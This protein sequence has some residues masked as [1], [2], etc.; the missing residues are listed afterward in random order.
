M[1]LITPTA[2]C[3]TA[4]TDTE[5]NEAIERDMEMRLRGYAH[6][7][8][9]I[10]SVRLRELD[11]EWNIERCLETGASGMMLFGLTMAAS[12]NRRWL[13]LPAAISGFLLQHALQGWCPPL[14]L[15]RRLGVRTAEEIGRERYA[16]KALRGDFEGVYDSQIAEEK[17]ENAVEGAY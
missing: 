16:L 7:S 5:L 8:K 11:E 13:V 10:I 2:D 17:V 6:E 4:N 1:K 3:V 15:L 12:V 9:A 14:P